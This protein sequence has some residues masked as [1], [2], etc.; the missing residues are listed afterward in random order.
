M[1]SDFNGFEAWSVATSPGR[2][3]DVHREGWPAT[4]TSGRRRCDP[5]GSSAR[6]EEER[7]GQDKETTMTNFNPKRAVVGGIAGTVAMTAL[8]LMAPK[9]GLPPMN[10][11]EM[12][13]SVMG[14]S[15]VLGWMGHFVIGTMLAVGYGLWFANRLPGP[16]VLRGAIFAVA[17]WLMAQL[18]VMPMMGAGIFSGSVLAAGGSLMGHLVYGAV[19]GAV[20][21]TRSRA[22]RSPRGL[23]VDLVRRLA[24][25]EPRSYRRQGG[26]QRQG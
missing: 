5:E 22:D 14:G 3:L 25:P 10:V 19:L 7:I 16:G 20:Y 21:G 17:P 23:P 26:L 11:G 8:M 15:V 12:L 1:S 2:R 13:G 4:H 9:M 24:K 18:V 6:T